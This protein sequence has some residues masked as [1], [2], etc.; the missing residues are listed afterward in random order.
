MRYRQRGVRASTVVRVMVFACYHHVH[1]DIG[2]VGVPDVDAGSNIVNRI[3]DTMRL[4]QSWDII[5]PRALT[6]LVML[7]NGSNT[8]QQ[9]ITNNHRRSCNP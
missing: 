2:W 5:R 9:H 4:R 3:V 6:F 1:N 7:L 8:A